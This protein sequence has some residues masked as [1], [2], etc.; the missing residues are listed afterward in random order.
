MKR[1]GS[2]RYVHRTALGQLGVRDRR[3]VTA[4]AARV[5]TFRWSVVRV[6]PDDVMLGQTTSFDRCDHP[7]LVASVRWDGRALTERRYTGD[8]RP[9]YHRCE[10]LLEPDHPR[11]AHF[12]RLTERESRAGLL[13]RPDIGTVGAWRRAML[14]SGRSGNG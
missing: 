14:A 10:Q 9:I 6:G 2:R 8:A 3:R 12:A 11:Y 4:L 5:P 7:A 13:S 1:V